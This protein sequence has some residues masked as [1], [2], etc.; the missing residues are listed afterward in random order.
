MTSHREITDALQ[1]VLKQLCA[2]IPDS[3]RQPDGILSQ[4]CITT[5]LLHL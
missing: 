3:M 1:E 2:V 5:S 4:V